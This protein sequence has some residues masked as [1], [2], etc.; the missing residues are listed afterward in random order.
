MI[1]Y[2]LLLLKCYD[3][4]AVN[5]VLIKTSEKTFRKWAWK[6]IHA[7]SRLNIVRFQEVHFFKFSNRVL[8]IM[9]FTF[10]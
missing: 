3:T 4:E 10:I 1:C 7:K 5:Q 8:D 2:G 9:V 6:S